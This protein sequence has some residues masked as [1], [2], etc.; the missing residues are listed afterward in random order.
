MAEKSKN[1]QED[2]NR[3]DEFVDIPGDRLEQIGQDTSQED[4]PER[5]TKGKSTASRKPKQDQAK[6]EPGKQATE[7]PEVSQDDL[8]ADIRQELAADEEVVEEHKGFFG[9]IFQ[10]LR[11]SSKTEVEE[12]ESQSQLEVEVETQE[13][14]SSDAGDLQGV[15]DELTE[16]SESEPKPKPKSRKKRT[17]QDTD[18]EKSIQ[19]FFADLE[20][21]ADVVPVGGIQATLE[22]QESAEGEPQEEE[23][24]KVPKL[25]VK[26]STE[27]EVDLE[28][29]R[30]LALEDYDETVIEPEERKK[31]LQEEVRQTVREL[32]PV[33]RFLLYAVGIVTVA[34]LLFSGGFLIVNSISVPTPAPTATL[35]LSETVYP[36]T[37]TITGGWKFPL[38]QGRVVDGTWAPSNDRAEW[39]VGTEISRWVALPWSLQ[40]E[41]V[42]RTLTTNDQ[43]ELTMSN[44]DVLTFNVYSIQQMTM[45]ELLA[46]DPTKPALLVVLYNDEEED[47]KFWT[48]TAVP[49][50]GE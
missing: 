14:V 43:L 47:G 7:S 22:E 25:P 31:P 30:G 40:L 3:D 32:K 4:K 26:S 5:N 27:D 13:E 8:L 46:T 9:R 29:I 20:A 6:E 21:L 37:L 39:L 2:Q 49:A 45:E 1:Q 38:G 44:F 28:E 42:L 15:L 17:A 11:G 24:V 34:V 23:K 10:R 50:R 16:E 33:E 18:E 19:E 41:A 36:T 35:D 48:V 12:S